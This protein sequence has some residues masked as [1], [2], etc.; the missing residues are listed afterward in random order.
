M[1]RR[2]AIIYHYII[3]S[4]KYVMQ[5]LLHDHTA[6][7][8]QCG[9]DWSQQAS[10]VATTQRDHTLCVSVKGVACKARFKGHSNGCKPPDLLANAAIHS[11]QLIRLP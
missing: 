8:E 6:I 11:V 10:A 5:L 4:A 9:S 1:L 7:Y 2:N 3:D